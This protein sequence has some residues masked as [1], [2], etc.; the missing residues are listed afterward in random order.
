MRLNTND[1]Q[2]RA[3]ARERYRQRI[4]RAKAGCSIERVAARYGEVRRSGPDRLVCHCLCGQNADRHPSF[5]LWP[6]D[7]RFHCFACGRGGSVI[8]LVILAEQLGEADDRHAFNEAL[9]ILEH[10]FGG[11][12]DPA[13]TPYVQRPTHTAK[14]ASLMDIDQRVLDA[15]TEWYH[16]QLMAGL[17]EPLDE[18][19]IESGGS[20]DADRNAD[21]GLTL[22]E[23][24]VKKRGLS[25]ATIQ[26]LKIGYSDGVGL[27]RHVH[28]LGL[29][30]ARLAEIG[31][32][33]PN[34][35]EHLRERIVF[36]VLRGNHTVYLIGRATKR[37][38]AEVKYLGL[39][40]GV[41]TKQPMIAGTPAAGG[42]PFRG[43]IF[44]EGAVDFA[45]LVNW[46]LDGE[47]LIVGLLGTACEAVVKDLTSSGQ[48]PLRAVLALDQDWAGKQAALKLALALGQHG[49]RSTV[50]VDADRHDVVG[51][52]VRRAEQKFE[53]TAREA[54]KLS[55]GQSEIETVA[56]LSTAGFA[57]W[58][59]W[60]NGVKDP[61]DLG[62][63][64]EEGRA[65]L[66]G[67]LAVAAS[68]S[69]QHPRPAP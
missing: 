53:L 9:Q 57:H 28:Q 16:T 25:L 13:S 44:V 65:M 56:E 45:V 4:A 55:S 52:W 33:T 41:V 54:A 14:L 1:E 46:G 7:N 19:L 61:G 32:I 31:L 17:D 11:A 26:R 30:V 36:P 15:T 24:L 10:D 40:S 59:H 39:P 37:W 42:T 2:Q 47:W 51:A 27:I 21:R 64:G 67:V 12:G 22:G 60:G 63:R 35:K 5:M 34:F 18:P 43:A 29:P 8:D 50:L 62:A 58:V 23:Y 3:Q 69:A 20:T 38:Q 48:L 49:V 6:A 66:I 68:S